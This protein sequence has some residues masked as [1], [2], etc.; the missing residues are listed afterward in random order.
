MINFAMIWILVGKLKIYLFELTLLLKF[1][2][3]S[4]EKET[5]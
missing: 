4:Q 3:R 5:V 2:K 1:F